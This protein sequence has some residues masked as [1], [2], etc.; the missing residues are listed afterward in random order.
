MNKMQK[1]I[2]I[3]VSGG[4][5][6]YKVVACASSLAQAGHSVHVAMSPGALEFVRPL[7]FAAVTGR[8]VI[9]SVFPDMAAADGEQL[10][11]HLYPAARTDIFLLAPASADML[12]RVACGMADD[13]VSASILALPPDCR[14]I[15]C[16]AMHVNMWAQE[17]VKENAEKL[18]ARGWIQLGP[19][20]GR[21]AC[22]SAGAGRMS[23]P[24]A[25]VA[26]V[27]ELIGPG[28]E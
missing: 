9:D 10:Y 6:A 1:T 21:L 28:E 14:K 22:G 17:V 27:L 8:R 4:I 23:E 15:F 13:A 24:E 3:G 26:K 2:M 20:P 11:P 19:E 12:A 16:P 25:I 7:S 18:R 5:A